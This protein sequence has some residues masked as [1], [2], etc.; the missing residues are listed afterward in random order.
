MKLIQDF[1]VRYTEESLGNRNLFYRKKNDLRSFCLLNW[2]T[3]EVE[4]EIT[5][6]STIYLS[7]FIN[8]FF[9]EF[10]SKL[11]RTIIRAFSFNS[12]VQLWE[13]DVSEIG[14]YRRP[15][16]FEDS[17]GEVLQFAGCYKGMLNVLITGGKYIA[18]NVDTGEL[19]WELKD[20][21]VNKTKQQFDFG[22][23]A[24]HPFLNEEEG[25]IYELQGDV[26]SIIDLKIQQA[27]FEWTSLD[28]PESEY[29]FFIQTKLF[30]NQIYFTASRLE[31]SGYADVIGV[32]DIATQKIIWRHQIDLGKRGFIPNSQEMLQVNEKRIGVLDNTGTLHVFEKEITGKT[33]E[34][35]HIAT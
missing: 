27:S 8:L 12:K 32:F 25:L 2:N 17:I 3:N 15:G 22:L 6:F 28:L 4:W 29:L 21:A 11:E 33:E 34:S 23:G 35:E 20:V 1:Y 5:Y 9:V 24:Y 13:Y 10:S 7:T 31:N 30:N 18:L 19:C 14:S 16:E 26:F